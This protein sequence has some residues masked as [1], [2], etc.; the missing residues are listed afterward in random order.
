MQEFSRE[1]MQIVNRPSSNERNVLDLFFSKSPTSYA[2]GEAWLKRIAAQE[3]D[4]EPE[5]KP[6]VGE[7]QLVALAKW[8]AIP[9][10]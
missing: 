10:N 5:A 7:A 9:A 4:R 3:L 1:V 6:K 8:G 2:A